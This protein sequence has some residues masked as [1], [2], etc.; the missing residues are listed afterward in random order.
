MRQI[1]AAPS[2]GGA[3]KST[4][5]EMTLL[6]LVSRIALAVVT[7]GYCLSFT[8]P[9]LAAD[10]AGAVS[11]YRRAHGLSAV[12]LDSRLDAV[13]RRQA[14]AMAASGTVSHSVGGIF[15]MRVANLRRAI[16]AENI[17]AGFLTFSEMLRQW[18][19][20]A[21][22]RENLL[23][24]QAR[25]VGVAFVDNPRSPYRKFWAMVITN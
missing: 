7:L 13:A 17:G 4:R 1:H 18:E 11:A 24:P 19:A 8:V 15:T 16:A 14:Q 3:T 6:P 12:T 9:A 2:A 22:H 23:I 21:G 20:S 25:R 10:Y 5:I